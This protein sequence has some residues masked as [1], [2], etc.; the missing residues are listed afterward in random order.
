MSENIGVSVISA[1][2]EIAM[3]RGQPAVKNL[4]HFDPPLI[5]GEM[6]RGLFPPITCIT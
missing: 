6:L 3:V 1:Q 5:Q 4:L 2:F